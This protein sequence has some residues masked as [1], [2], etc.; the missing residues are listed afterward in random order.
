MENVKDEL[1]RSKQETDAAYCKV[2][3]QDIPQATAKN[4]AGIQLVCR[5]IKNHDK[6]ISVGSECSILVLVSNIAT[7]N[8]FNVRIYPIIHLPEHWFI[9]ISLFVR[10]PLHVMLLVTGYGSYVLSGHNNITWS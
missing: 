6:L 9:R 1:R 5:T 10:V 2:L 3:S 4:H 7:T 8:K